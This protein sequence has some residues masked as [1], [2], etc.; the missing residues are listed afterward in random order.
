MARKPQ[1]PHPTA[2]ST[3][4]G[5][6]VDLKS[7][8]IR[9]DFE[10]MSEFV[11]QCALPP[12]R[13][14]AGRSFDSETGAPSFTMSDSFDHAMTL[15]REGWPSGRERMVRANAM[16][17]SAGAVLSGPAYT[18]DVGGAY[19]VASLAAAGDPA[20]MVSFAPS[21]ERVRPI[22]RLLV[23]GSVSARYMANEIFNYGAALS[24]IIDGLEQNDV[25][26]EI[27]V[28]FP[29]EAG[30]SKMSCNVRIKEAGEPL[31]LDTLAFAIAHP[32][33][34]RRLTFRFV[35]QNCNPEH[36]GYGYGRPRKPEYGVD[37]DPD[38]TML[39]GP[40]MFPTGSRQLS[41]PE[42]AFK[43]M[44]PVIMAQLA[45]RYTTFP[46]LCFEAA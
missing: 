46:D 16:A 9:R 6:A 4:T 40:Q 31:N 5:P 17:A 14:W 30:G 23:N 19:P 27:T 10:S 35:E 2:T 1:T 36:Y 26:C 45:D 42:N 12:S 24:S 21:N 3:A 29:G 8:H 18:L 38:M 25:R 13:S 44:A 41:S 28:C 11:A 37:A 43:A 32:S 20:C 39:A 7:K 22:V 15:A 33:M 34:L